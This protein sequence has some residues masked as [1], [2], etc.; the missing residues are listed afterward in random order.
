[1]RT[2]I[3]ATYVIVA[4]VIVSLA[5]GCKSGG[6]SAKI[7]VKDGAANGERLRIAVLPFDNVSR[8]QDA[9][10]VVTNTVITYLLSTGQ[11]DVVE[12]G[13]VYSTLT[14]ERIRLT[15]GITV[16]DL[17]LMEPRLHADAIIMGLV[18]EYGDVRIGSDSYPAI[19]FSAR[20]VDARTAEILWAATISKTGADRIKVF[21]IGRVSSVGK[22]AKQAVN[23]MAVSLARSRESIMANMGPGDGDVPPFREVGDD[24]ETPG[25]LIP[26]KREIP[27]EP[28]VYT[29]EELVALLKD[30]GSAK[31]GTVQYG[32]HYHS[33][34]ETRYTL[35]DTGKFVEVKLVDYRNK[36]TAEKFLKQYHKDEQ[37]LTFETL[38]AYENESGYGY[39]HLDVAVGQFVMSLRG[40]KGRRGDIESLAT[41]IIGL[42]M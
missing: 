2:G 19:S 42:L 25:D 38:P 24:G 5:A 21:D 16:A 8:N 26:L 32:K 40:P 10:R 3:V 29:E 39:F 12:P 18:E 4:A 6:P 20:L 7:F 13:V 9:G 35:G 17:G 15:E 28:A 31:V 22:L 11:F 41:G 34:V 27:S 33:R 37:E 1:M 36:E 23:D 14:E 30:V